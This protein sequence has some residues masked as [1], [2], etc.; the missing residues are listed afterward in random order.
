[1]VLTGLAEI[2]H[3][4]SL[5]LVEAFLE[6]AALQREA[7]SAYAKIAESI[8]SREPATAKEA[9]QRVVDKAAD[10]GLRKKA[11]SALDKIK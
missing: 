9:L 3:V 2:S 8:A 10:D 4:E 5:K 1:L 6:D 11:K 7:F